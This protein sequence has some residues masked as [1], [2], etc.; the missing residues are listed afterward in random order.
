MLDYLRRPPDPFLKQLAISQKRFL[1]PVKLSL[2]A[3]LQ[4][5]LAALVALVVIGGLVALVLYLLRDWLTSDISDLGRRRRG[6]R[7]R[8]SSWRRS[9]SST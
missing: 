7:L 2:R 5:A 8:G 9:S 6:P 1:K 3:K 4:A